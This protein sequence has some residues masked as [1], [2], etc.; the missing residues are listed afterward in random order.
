M[1]A[2]PPSESIL[3]RKWSFLDLNSEHE[4]QPADAEQPAVAP[5][6]PPQPTPPAVL[7]DDAVTTALEAER[8]KAREREGFIHQL[9]SNLAESKREVAR[10]THELETL[11]L[12]HYRLNNSHDDLIASLRK[13]HATVEKYTSQRKGLLS[14]LFRR[15]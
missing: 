11:Q 12:R 9:Q 3:N 13:A 14:R 6:E 4:L 10:L 8:A 5:A 15:H 1:P 2:E 7:S